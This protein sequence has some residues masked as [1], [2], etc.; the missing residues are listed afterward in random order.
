MTR[1]LLLGGSGQLGTAIARRWSDCEIVAPSHDELA[2]EQS[3]RL[4]DALTSTRPDVLVNAAA[5]HDV[6]RCEDEQ[7]TA[8]EINAFSVGRAAR[9]AAQRD[10]LFVTMST[11]YVFDGAKGSPYTESDSP[12]PLSLYGASKLAGERLVEAAG[13]RAFVVRTCGVYGPSRSTS[14]RRTFIDRILTA[15]E[16]GE[17]VR[18]VADVVASPTF[19][20]DLADALRKLI[21]TTAYGLYH[22]AAAGPVSWYEFACEAMRQARVEFA[23]EPI[24]G[25]QWKARAIRPRYSALES[26]K[27]NELGIAMPPWREGIAAYLALG[28]R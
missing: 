11:D 16:S 19:A 26:A 27:R 18:V 4:D 6:D 12:N 20:G 9:L 15:G 10:V 3:A 5:F 23:I 24:A 21:G 13:G 22:A 28:V 7:K 17:S 2:I 14:R 25:N 1:V 8:L